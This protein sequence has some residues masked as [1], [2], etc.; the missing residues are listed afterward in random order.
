MVRPTNNIKEFVPEYFRRTHITMFDESYFVDNF[1]GCK[2]ESTF[3]AGP[4]NQDS[5]RGFAGLLF[6]FSNA[7]SW[8]RRE[9]ENRVML[10][11]IMKYH[12]HGGFEHLASLTADL[13]SLN[14]MIALPPFFDDTTIFS[15][16]P[17]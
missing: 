1:S 13:K 4:C 15:I 16:L 17:C 11:P 8:K 9:M 10:I 7:I 3:E 6:T 2:L 5:L 12:F 14:S